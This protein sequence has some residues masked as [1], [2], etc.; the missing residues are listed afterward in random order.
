MNKVFLI[1]LVIIGL[2]VLRELYIIL[3]ERKKERKK[4]FQ[5]AQQKSKETGKPLLVIGDPANDNKSIDGKSDYG[6]GDVCVDKETGC[7]ICTIG[8]KDDIENY[9]PK[10]KYNSYIIFSS[11]VLEYVNNFEKIKEELYRV[12]GGDLFIVHLEPYTFKTMLFKNLGYT[13]FPRKR[14]IYSAP[15][16]S[17]EI[18]YKELK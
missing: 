7:N 16:D 2:I 5:L 14:I 12:S 10:L 17:K 11:C 4:I 3:I 6:C 15:P 18:I 8:I 9:L 13:K 1:I